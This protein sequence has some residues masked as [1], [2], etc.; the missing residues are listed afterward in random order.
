MITNNMEAAINKY[1]RIFI[2]VGYFDSLATIMNKIPSA[3][4]ITTAA[5]Y[6]GV[7]S[8]SLS[9][10]PIMKSGKRSIDAPARIKRKPKKLIVNCIRICFFVLECSTAER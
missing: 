9:I 3:N 2:T 5:I 4:L 7:S 10:Q 6:K 8:I 1:P